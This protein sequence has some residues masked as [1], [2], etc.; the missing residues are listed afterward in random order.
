MPPIYKLANRKQNKFKRDIL[1]RVSIAVK[2]NHDQGNFYLG[3]QL[4]G[5]GITVSDVQSIIIMGKS[6]AV[7]RQT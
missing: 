5:A 2:R 4:I 1:V 7:C 3:Q 6:I